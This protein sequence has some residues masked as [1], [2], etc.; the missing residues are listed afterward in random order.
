MSK[1]NQITDLYYKSEEFQ[2][3]IPTYLHPILAV[4]LLLL[5]FSSILINIFADKKV[6]GSNNFVKLLNFLI[7]GAVCALAG[8]FGAIF[9]SSAIGV[10]S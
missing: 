7:V 1:F 2:P 6:K 4:L 10:Y 9:L 3:G 5:A 8:G